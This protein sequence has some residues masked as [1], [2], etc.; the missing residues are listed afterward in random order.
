M[1]TF[2]KIL[3]GAF[4]A[5]VLGFAGPALADNTGSAIYFGYN[6]ATGLEFTHGAD[7]S[8][9][10]S[11]VITGTAGCGTLTAKTTGGASAGSVTLGTFATSCTLTITFPSAAPNGWYC[12]FADLSVP[13]AFTEASTTTTTCVT[14]VSTTATTGNVVV[15]NAVGY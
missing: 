8:G 2:S 15:W 1:K 10:V 14:N 3:L 11:P 4:L 7:V 12:T 9:G 6:P 13:T 5:T